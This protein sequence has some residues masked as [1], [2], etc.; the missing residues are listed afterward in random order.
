VT[1][2]QLAKLGLEKGKAHP[3]PGARYAVPDPAITQGGGAANTAVGLAW[4]GIPCGLFGTLG[5]DELG[6]LYRRDLTRHRI[7]PYVE[8]EQGQS[9]VAYT[10]ITPDGERT[11]AYDLGVAPRFRTTKLM[12]HLPLFDVFYTTGYELVANPQHTIP[13]LDTARRRGLTTAF[14]LAS[15]AAI[16]EHE[17]LFRAALNYVDIV[18]ANEDEAAELEGSVDAALGWLSGRCGMAVVKLG[19]NGSKVASGGNVYDIQ[20]YDAK[21]F[22][23]TNGA[24]DRC[25]RPPRQPVR[26][27]G[28]RA[29]RGEDATEA[30][31]SFQEGIP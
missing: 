15:A 19:E 29:G 25:L 6:E 28:L 11:F 5:T 16:N 23:N 2:E 9:G 3:R 24:G 31:G 30:V 13:F 14:D 10:F 26:G 27:Q 4:L 17:Y 21:G 20:R 18:F 22:R 8:T 12:Q 7:R 1:D